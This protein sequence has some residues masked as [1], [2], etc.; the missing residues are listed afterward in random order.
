M[1]ACLGYLV[2]LKLSV[3]YITLEHTYI[4]SMVALYT[5][6][7]LKLMSSEFIMNLI[8]ICYCRFQ[9]ILEVCNIFQM[10][11]ECFQ[12]CYDFPILGISD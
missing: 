2:H 8:S 11:Y 3:F 4:Y 1:R 12:V 10:Y 7:F 6:L 9:V 5:L